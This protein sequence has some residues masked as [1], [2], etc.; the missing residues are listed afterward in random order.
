[1]KFIEWSSAGLL[2][3][4]FV[5][6]YEP[7]APLRSLIAF[8]EFINSFHSTIFAFTLTCPG[9]DR[10]AQLTLLSSTREQEEMKLSGGMDWRWA[11]NT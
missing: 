9:E 2:W 8:Q 1:M 6:G 11:T 7:E 4:G 3:F 5:G 10:A